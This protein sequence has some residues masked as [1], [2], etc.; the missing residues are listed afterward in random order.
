VETK[1]D[2]IEPTHT[3]F[4]DAMEFFEILRLDEPQVREYARTALRLAHGI[5]MAASGERYVHAWV[6]ERL[7]GD[8]PERVGW[9][10]VVVWQGMRYGAG[11]G[12][13]AVDAEWFHKSYQV[14]ECVRYEAQRFAML[15][16][17]TGHYGPWE[18][19]YLAMMGDSPGGRLLGSVEG[20]SPLGYVVLEGVPL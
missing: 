11:K 19:R 8:D 10:P 5:C 17:R 13:F 1:P 12:W 20:A 6:E 9:P 18:P 2:P 15:N 4:D 7:E 16:L 14:Q 3:C